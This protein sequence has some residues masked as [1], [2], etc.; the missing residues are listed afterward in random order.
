MILDV[1]AHLDSILIEDD[2]L[3]AEL[4][5]YNGSPAIAFQVAPKDMTMP[6][7]VTTSVGNTADSNYITDRSLYG[8]D[9]YVPNGDIARA[10][11]IA[12]HV[13]ELFNMSML[14]EDIGLNI[15]KEWDNFLPEDDPSI[16]RYH[17]EFGLRHI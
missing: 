10:S 12:A 16:I 4:A 3:K 1:L 8:I 17:V 7:L 9:I 5:D 2:L 13:I 11:R 6:Y 15:W 14:P